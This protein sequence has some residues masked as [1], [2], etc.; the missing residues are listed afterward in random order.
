MSKTD[1]ILETSYIFCS[2][3][4]IPKKVKVGEVEYNLIFQLDK[5]FAMAWEKSVFL[6]N[7]LTGREEI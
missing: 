5:G 1:D 7:H 2:R 3:C 4:P 6:W